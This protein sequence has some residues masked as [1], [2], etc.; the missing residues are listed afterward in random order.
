MSKYKTTL[1]YGGGL[2]STCNLV[3]LKD[4]IKSCVFVDYGQRAARGELAACKYFTSKYNIPLIIVENFHI[5]RY[6]SDLQVQLFTGDIKHSPYIKGR[7]LSLIMDAL[8]VSEKV[9]VG[10]EKRETPFPDCSLEFIQSTNKILQGLFT[11]NTEVIAPFIFIDR[12]QLIKSAYKIDRE[13]FDKAWSCWISEGNEPCGV[14]KH[15]LQIKEYK[16]LLNIQ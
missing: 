12:F 5:K 9:Y 14:C 7:N 16:Q 10:F 8:Q 3:L 15:C 6:N 11:P 2:D 4:I 1:L 13:I